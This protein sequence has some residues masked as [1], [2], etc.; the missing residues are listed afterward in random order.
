MQKLPGTNR[1]HSGGPVRSSVFAAAGG[2]RRPTL[3]KCFLGIVPQFGHH[4]LQMTFE[5]GAAIPS[6]AAAIRVMPYCDMCT[7]SPRS[8]RRDEGF[9][10]STREYADTRLPVPENTMP[11]AGQSHSKVSNRMVT[12][13]AQIVAAMIT[14]EGK[15]DDGCRAKI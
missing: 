3:P 15:G 8:A 5:E 2:S 11:L 1:M 12:R 13:F 10:R 6:H 9:R 4:R 7:Q 14:V